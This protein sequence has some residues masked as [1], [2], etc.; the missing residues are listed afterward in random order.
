MN[1]ARYIGL[2]VL[3]LAWVALAAYT[4]MYSGVNL[5]NL[6][7]IVFS[8]IIIFVPLW[9]KYFQAGDRK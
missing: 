8:A 9:K 3:A 5:K 2:A 4:L 6:L 7:I 1:V